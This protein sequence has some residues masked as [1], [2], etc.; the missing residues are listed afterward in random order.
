MERWARWARGAKWARGAG[1]RGCEVGLAPCRRRAVRGSA[2]W[3]RGAAG[4]AAARLCKLGQRGCGV[5]RRLEAEDG[6]GEEHARRTCRHFHLLLAHARHRGD[7]GRDGSQHRAAREGKGSGWARRMTHGRARATGKAA[8]AQP[9]RPRDGAPGRRAHGRAWTA[10]RMKVD[11]GLL[12]ASTEPATT[13][14]A[15]RPTPMLSPG[16]RGGGGSGGGDAGGGTGGREG[17]CSG[18]GGLWPSGGAG[19]SGG[20]GGCDGGGDGGYPMHTAT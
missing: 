3:G 7:G 1:G 13:S 8:R 2:A 19:G 12:N 11:A 10:A 5:A 18:G 15:R 6:D 20:G 17:G 4:R 16:E 14:D 9:W